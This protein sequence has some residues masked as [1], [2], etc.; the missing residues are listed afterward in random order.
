MILEDD[1]DL[2]VEGDVV[3]FSTTTSD[4]KLKDNVVNIKNPL[5][6]ITKLRGVEFDWNATSRK[7]QHDIGLIAQEVEK[8]IP[9]VVREKPLKT[10]DFAN[11]EKTYKTVDYEKIVAV[12]VESTKEQQK[13]IED[14]KKEIKELKK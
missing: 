11:N 13:Q 12:L 10:G 8:V 2:H 1:G 14:L 5:D 7:G 4:K 6:K 3:A 9:D